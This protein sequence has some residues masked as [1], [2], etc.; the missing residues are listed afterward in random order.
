MLQNILNLDGVTV[1]NKKQQNSI[2]GGYLPE[3]TCAVQGGNGYAGVSGISI[4]YA[5]EA[6]AA[7]GGHW[8]CDSCQS[9]TW[10]SQEHKDYLAE[11]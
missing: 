8:C 10:L 5:Q 4:A 7:T 11:M 1:L 9:A 6:A 2:N 3:G